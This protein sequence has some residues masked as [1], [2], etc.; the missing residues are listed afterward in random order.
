MFQPL[1]NAVNEDFFRP[2]LQKGWVTHRNASARESLKAITLERYL[3][4]KELFPK[5]P[6][7]YLQGYDIH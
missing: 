1:R 7:G 5:D 2:P 3:K 6:Q 4:V